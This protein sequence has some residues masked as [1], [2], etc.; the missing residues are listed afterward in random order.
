MLSSTP[1][2][3]R[4]RLGELLNFKTRDDAYCKSIVR[5]VTG[6]Q[7]SDRS[8][9]Y[10]YIH[11][12]VCMGD[13]SGQE[14]RHAHIT[15]PSTHSFTVCPC[16]LARAALQCSVV[17]VL[18]DRLTLL[19]VYLHLSTLIHNRHDGGVTRRAANGRRACAWAGFR[20]GMEL[21]LCYLSH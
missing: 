9:R 6:P 18:L 14:D 8:E 1:S 21:H 19:P 3:D 4:V 11:R 17:G 12:T 15:P 20:G 10:S 13:N 2:A 16:T 7:H 5:R